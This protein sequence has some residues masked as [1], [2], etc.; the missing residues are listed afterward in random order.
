M[1]KV[2]WQD[3]ESVIAYAYALGPGMTV[4]KHPDRANYNITHTA[5]PDRW[6]HWNYEIVCQT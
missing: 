4:Y 6:K 5:Q 3:R 2:D 1:T